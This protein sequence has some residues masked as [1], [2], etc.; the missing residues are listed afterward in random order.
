MK[1]IEKVKL[2][3]ERLFWKN[4]YPYAISIIMNFQ[5]EGSG[6][7]KY[8]QP[9]EGTGEESDPSLRVSHQG[10]AQV[11]SGAQESPERGNE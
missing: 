3:R 5:I 2:S 7:E 1:K 8:Q 9:R 11:E 10:Q 4:R 6:K